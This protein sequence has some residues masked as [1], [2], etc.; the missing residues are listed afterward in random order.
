MGTYFIQYLHLINQDTE[1]TSDC[2]VGHKDQELE[3]RL[4]LGSHVWFLKN[5]SSTISTFVNFVTVDFKP[6]EG[7][8]C[9]IF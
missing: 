4:K 2:H 1:S 7:S 6:L 3:V 5:H 9:L 8:D